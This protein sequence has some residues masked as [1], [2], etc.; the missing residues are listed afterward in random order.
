MKVQFATIE[1]DFAFLKE[2]DRHIPP[3]ITYQKIEQGKVLVI[4]DGATVVGWLRFGFFWDLIPM[5]NMLMIEESYRGKGWG[6]ELVTFW[7][8]EMKKRGYNQVMTST[9]SDEQAQ[10]FYRKLGYKDAGA[11]LLPDEALEIILIKE[12]S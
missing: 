6:R 1:E 9:L 8:V 5:M 12:L 3:E 7:E 11:L 4:K 2:N 10:H